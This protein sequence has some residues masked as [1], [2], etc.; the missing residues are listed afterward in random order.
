MNDFIPPQARILTPVI[1]L[2][3]IITVLQDFP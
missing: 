3:F 1:T 2:D